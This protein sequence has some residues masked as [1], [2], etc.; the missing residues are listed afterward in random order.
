MGWISVIRELFINATILI[1]FIFISNQ[2][3]FNWGI[4]TSDSFKSKIMYGIFGGLLGC[5]LIVF[6]VPVTKT[7]V[8]DYRFIPILICS[9][10][11][12]FTASAISGIMISIFRI[13]GFGLSTASI[14]GGITAAVMSFGCALIGKLNI[15]NKKKWIYSLL[16]SLISSSIS[17]SFSMNDVLLAGKASI[18]FV[19][20]SCIVCAFSYYLLHYLKTSNQLIKKLMEESS[21]DFLTGLNNVRTF[22]NAI[23]TAI[24]S[25]LET[26]NSLSIL[27]LDIDFFKK[28]NDTYGHPAGDA[29]LKSLGDILLRS[30]RKIDIVCRVGGEE[31]SV[32]L[33]DTKIDQALEIGEKIRN[34]V[35]SHI[36]ILPDGK[37][38]HITISIGVSCY[39]E[40]TTSIEEL[41][42]QGDSALYNAKHTGRNK[43]SL[44]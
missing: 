26:N 11:G 25:T 38:I 39:P 31:F 44:P 5:T 10:Y 21:M 23:N 35:E 16:F 1:S 3:F 42:R 8:I 37:K 33:P 17:F 27:M 19:I 36:F 28:V 14:I 7:S 34:A 6:S 32:I 24:K 22:D 40:T 30:C 15:E 41:I 43:V 20:S 13:L 18:Y 12:G 4:D 29:V 9:I 2:L